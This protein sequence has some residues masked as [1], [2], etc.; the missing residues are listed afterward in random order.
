MMIDA[1]QIEAAL[2][3]L[4]RRGP[5]I[6]PNND[7]GAFERIEKDIG[8][9]LMDAMEFYLN[10]VAKSSVLLNLMPNPMAQAAAFATGMAVVGLIKNEQQHIGSFGDV[11]EPLSQKLR[12][13]M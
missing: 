3:D 2:A 1:K 6:D 7:R 9:N 12:R 11:D 4:R 5:A 10:E 13:G 8:V